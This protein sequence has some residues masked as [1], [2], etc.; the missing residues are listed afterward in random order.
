MN[1]YLVDYE[2]AKIKEAMDLPGL[3]ADDVV[4]IF[5]SDT[6]IFIK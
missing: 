3:K 6:C 1:Y 2:N 4:I 5:Y